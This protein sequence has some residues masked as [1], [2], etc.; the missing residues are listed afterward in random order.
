MYQPLIDELEKMELPYDMCVAKVFRDFDKYKAVGI[1]Y[2][3]IA[4]Q[5][6]GFRS[7]NLKIDNYD[8]S[9]VT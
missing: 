5:K 8:N 9:E 7:D 3:G 4:Y 6:A 1:L 2:K